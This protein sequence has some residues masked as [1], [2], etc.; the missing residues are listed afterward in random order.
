M[1][2]TYVTRNGQTMVTSIPADSIDVALSE[3][4]IAGAVTGRTYRFYDPQDPDYTAVEMRTAYLAGYQDGAAGRFNATDP[5]EGWEI[6]AGHVDGHPVVVARHV[7]GY[8]SYPN[9]Y[10]KLSGLVRDLITGNTHDCQEF[11][12]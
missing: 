12:G 2:K 6:A 11:R 8:K 5:T 10:L 9:S 3:L 1:S 4:A 7:C